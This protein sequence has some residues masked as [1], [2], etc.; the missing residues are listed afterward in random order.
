MNLFIDTVQFYRT[1]TVVNPSTSLMNWK[2]VCVDQINE[3][4]PQEAF[5]FLDSGRSKAEMIKVEAK[6]KQKCEDPR[7]DEAN[8]QGRR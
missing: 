6:V 2:N 7:P 5:D 8:E 1:G 4:N 3:R